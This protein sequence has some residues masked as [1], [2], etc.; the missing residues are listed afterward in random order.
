MDVAARIAAPHLLRHQDEIF[1][2][3]A[4]Q[5]KVLR[6][7]VETGELS[8]STAEDLGLLPANS[9]VVIGLRR[10]VDH[11]LSHAARNR[12]VE[13]VDLYCQSYRWRAATTA[14]G[15]TIYCL[16]AFGADRVP[17]DVTT[18][19]HGLADNARRTMQSPMHVA[20]SEQRPRL[21]S[22][23]EL[24]D[25]VDGVLDVLGR[26]ADRAHA[27]MRFPDAVPQIL[28][29]Q[30]GGLMR[31]HPHAAYHKLEVLRR[32]DELHGT[33]HIRTLRVFLGAFGNVR[34]ASQ[35][36]GLH[37]T[38]LRYRVRRLTELSGIDLGNVDERLFCELMLRE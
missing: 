11:T 29:D 27:V 6:A 28:L 5:R 7:L 32:S 33:E 9:Y 19:A 31:A 23:P 8:R 24:R 2:R 16:L 15:H 18:L 21:A 26:P 20:V 12:L 10:A 37:P 34:T 17:G 30:F 14:V 4:A 1:G 3:R 38:T 22:A 25:Q 13:S 36:L 35:R